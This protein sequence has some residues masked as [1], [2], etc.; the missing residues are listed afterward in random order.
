MKKFD[1]REYEEQ[2]LNSKREKKV[3]L[4]PTRFEGPLGDIRIQGVGN[5]YVKGNSMYS[6]D[7]M[8]EIEK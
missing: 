8:Y 4:P 7:M 2:R 5:F 3:I 1:I 6:T